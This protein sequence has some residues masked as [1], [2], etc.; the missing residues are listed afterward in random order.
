[1][2]TITDF[3]VA[4]ESQYCMSNVDFKFF[5]KST[6]SIVYPFSEELKDNPTI[7]G[8]QSN[9]H[10]PKQNRQESNRATSSGAM[11]GLM[12]LETFAYHSELARTFKA[13]LKSGFP[14]GALVL[15]AAADLRALRAHTLGYESM[16][17]AYQVDN[18]KRKKVCNLIST[19]QHTVKCP[20]S[21]S[22]N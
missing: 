8:S 17:H 20:S 15:S 12:I 9:T 1:M 2:P 14:A 5:I 3:V 10:L 16:K 21:F 4:Q 18:V 6:W 13:K 19:P 22:D 7:A 11:R